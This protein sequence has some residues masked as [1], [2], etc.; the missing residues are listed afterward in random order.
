MHLE[1]SK[2]DPGTKVLFLKR[3]KKFVSPQ[4]SWTDQLIY[5][6][7]KSFTLLPISSFEYQGNRIIYTP[8][9]TFSKKELPVSD[10]YTDSGKSDFEKVFYL[11]TDRYGRDL[12]SRLIVGTRIS[13]AIGFIAVLISLLIGIILGLISGYYGGSIDRFIMWLINVVWSVPTLLMVIAISLALGRG[14]WQVFTAVGLTMWVELARVVRGQVMSLKELDYIKAAKMLG[15]SDFR[16]IFRHVLPNITSPIIV[17]SA[18]NFASAILIEAGL[19]FL[20]IGTQ[21]PIPSWGVMI[22]NHYAYIILDKAY[23]AIAPGLAIVFLV[24]AFMLVGNMLREKL[25]VKNT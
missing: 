20:G 16:I 18:A 4:T 7:I 1:L 6:E 17:I 8:Y 2:I 21:A 13:L 11:G 10:L 9:N 19:S 25:Q 23:L 22:K 14:F 15:F 24:L 5:G 12:L 3:K